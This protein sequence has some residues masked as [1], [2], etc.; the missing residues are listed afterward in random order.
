MTMENGSSGQMIR[1]RIEQTVRNY[2]DWSKA[3]LH[4]LEEITEE[5]LSHCIN[6]T[7]NRF[8]K[9]WCENNLK[10]IKMKTI[11]SQIRENDRGE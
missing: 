2:P 3:E 8:I 10:G 5:I 9:E 7:G 1:D 4:K 11:G 6:G